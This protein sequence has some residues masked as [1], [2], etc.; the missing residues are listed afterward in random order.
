MK[1]KIFLILIFL[2]PVYIKAEVSYVTITRED[3][4]NSV[5]DFTNT[6]EINFNKHNSKE[7]SKCQSVRIAKYWFITAAHCVSDVCKDEICSFRARLIV[8][9]NYEADLTT[10]HG[11]QFGKK[12]FMFSKTRLNTKET[13]YDI[14]LIYF[15]PT[16]SK[17]VFKDPR[18]FSPITE[19]E[20]LNR[21]PGR[22]VYVRAVNGTNLPTI[23]ALDST[24]PLVLKR[25]LSVISIWSGK[26][27]L[28][29]STKEPIYYSPLLAHLITKNFGVIKGISGSGV[30]TNTGELVGI[31]SAKADLV[32]KKGS[33]SD[34]EVIPLVYVTPFDKEIMDFITEFIPNISYI[35]ADESYYRNLTNK[36]KQYLQ[37]IESIKFNMK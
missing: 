35:F 22:A 7:I 29:Q 34:T 14:A 6:Y 5:K 17:I 31:V 12:I 24:N 23:L 3:S 15:N 28:L 9:P 19:E 20:F 37:V 16:D 10:V 27:E 25:D 11:K 33:K 13:L 26:K 1:I 32:I 30:M 8:G 18:Y 4:Y 36:E 21:I 2:L